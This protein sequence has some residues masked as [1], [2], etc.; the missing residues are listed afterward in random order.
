[1]ELEWMG[2]PYRF[3][4]GHIEIQKRDGTWIQS[5]WDQTPPSEIGV[6][7]ESKH[8]MLPLL[9]AKFGDDPNGR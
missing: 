1:M 6:Y 8:I 9:E 5:A 7:K 2:R 4:Q 3:H